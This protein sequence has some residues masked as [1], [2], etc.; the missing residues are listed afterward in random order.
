MQCPASVYVRK[1]AMWILAMW[2]SS[3]GEWVCV[4]Y[5]DIHS[6]EMRAMTSYPR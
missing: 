5:E 1:A 2:I 6:N 3:F 4:P